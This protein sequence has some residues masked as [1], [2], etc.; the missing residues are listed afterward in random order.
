MIHLSPHQHFIVFH[1]LLIF[2]AH[3][4]TQWISSTGT[5]TLVMFYF[6]M[7]TQL[8]GDIIVPQSHTQTDLFVPTQ[9][10][11]ISILAQTG[12]P[13]GMHSIPFPHLHST[14]AMDLFIMIITCKENWNNLQTSLFF[15]SRAGQRSLLLSMASQLSFLEKSNSLEK[16]KGPPFGADQILEKVRILNSPF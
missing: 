5:Y 11:S 9:G 10:G 12:L 6:H 8:F 7:K 16:I 1:Q 14:G 3:G 13:C 2:Q 4:D 15:T